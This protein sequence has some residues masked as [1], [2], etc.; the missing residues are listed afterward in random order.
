MLKPES[1]KAKTKRI[2]TYKRWIKANPPDENGRWE[3][4]LQISS[5]CPKSLS[6]NLLSLE[7][8]KPR[9]KNPEL[10]YKIENIK[11]SCLSCNEM[12]GSRTIEEL[13]KIWPHLL[14]YMDKEN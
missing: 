3:C 8:V 1:D 11:P 12:K 5:M 7:H 2:A 10:K 14:K 4:Y 9:S 6:R 13:S